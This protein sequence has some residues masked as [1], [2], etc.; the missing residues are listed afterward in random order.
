[1]PQLFFRFSALASSRTSGLN[2]CVCWGI[3]IHRQRRILFLFSAALLLILAGRNL[4]HD[5]LEVA[6]VTCGAAMLVCGHLVN[7]R[8]CE[9]CGTCREESGQA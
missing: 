3:R 8:L 7:R 6:F 9:S 1:L 5:A 2:K 4:A